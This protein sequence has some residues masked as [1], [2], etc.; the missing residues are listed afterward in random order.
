MSPLLTGNTWGSTARP[1]AQGS[2]EAAAGVGAHRHGGP[3]GRGVEQG[4]LRR[5]RGCRERV[6]PPPQAL[7]LVPTGDALPEQGV[8]LAPARHLLPAAAAGLLRGRRLCSAWARSALGV[9]SQT[10]LI[11]RACCEL[12]LLLGLCMAV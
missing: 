2:T 12:L 11:W 10:E 8:G 7:L 4:V 3:G 9:S 6:I 5:P 1:Q